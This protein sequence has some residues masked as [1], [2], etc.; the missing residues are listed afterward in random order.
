MMP[1]PEYEPLDILG[2]F[3]YDHLPVEQRLVASQCADVALMMADHLPHNEELLTGLRKLLEAKDCFVRA[4]ITD[5]GLHKWISQTRWARGSV[6]D[7][8]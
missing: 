1:V 8:P 5:V 3:E 7:V 4:S 2:W 6:T